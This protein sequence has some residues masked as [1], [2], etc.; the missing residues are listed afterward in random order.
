MSQVNDILQKFEEFE[1]SV[2]THL[3]KVDPRLIVDLLLRQKTEP[4]NKNPIY[5][6]E[7]FIKPNQNTDEIRNRIINETGKTIDSDGTQDEEAISYND[8]FDALGYR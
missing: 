7:V 5:T 2:K 4:N 6:L 8:I 1:T 3:A